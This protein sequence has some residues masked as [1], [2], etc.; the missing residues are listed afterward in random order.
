M[1]VSESKVAFRQ[2][3]FPKQS[4]PRLSIFDPEADKLI[5][6]ERPIVLT[7][8][9]LIRPALKWD[10]EYLESH[11]GPGNYTVFQSKTCKFKY[12]DDTKVQ[13]ER[14]FADF[15]PPTRRI[16]MKFPEFAVKLRNWKSGDDRIYLQQ[17]LNSTVGQAIVEDFVRF[18]WN[19]ANGRQ[20]KNNW[21]SLTSNLLLIA[22]EG[23]ITPCHYDEQQNF[24]AQ[25]RGS[26]RVF[27][28]PPE[29]FECLYPYPVYHPHDRQ[30]QVD[31]DNPD[32]ERFPKFREIEAMEAVVEPGDVLY[33]PM[34]WW[35]HV[36]SLQTGGYTVSV[37]FWYRAGPTG[38]IE[39]PLKAQQKV[40]IIRNVEKMVSGA[41]E[42]PEEVGPLLRAMVLGRYT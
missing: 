16:D 38:K 23:N 37:N 39:Y 29:Q 32:Y 25:V 7:D 20:K 19:W 9:N 27:L 31:F 18:N 8:S 6:E 11:L 36:E 21:G 35:H 10:L 34:Y 2:Y 12:Y 17:T 5:S 14:I 33:I 24:F 3:D 28:F 22:T 30:S 26:K 15:V 13:D 4:I 42:K 40:A 41:L 1:A